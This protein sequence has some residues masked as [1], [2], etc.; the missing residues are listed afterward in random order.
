MIISS[1]LHF[2]M[3]LPNETALYNVN[4]EGRYYQNHNKPTRKEYLEYD[5][6]YLGERDDHHHLHDHHGGY[7]HKENSHG[8]HLVSY[9]TSFHNDNHKQHKYHDI[10]HG[11][12]KHDVYLDPYLILAGIGT[13]ALLSFLAFRILTTTQ[14][15]NAGRSFRDTSERT[16][17]IGTLIAEAHDIYG[18]AE[19]LAT[20]INYIWQHRTN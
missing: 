7:N 17:K 16:P 13:G 20:N 10:H 1:A 14:A 15:A 3:N 19:M 9:H 8:S 4:N 6:E 2:V 18:D 11:H 12:H 5:Y